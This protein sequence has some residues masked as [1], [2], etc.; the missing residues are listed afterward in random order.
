LPR[1]AELPAFAN[2]CFGTGSTRVDLDL[3][4]GLD[5]TLGHEITTTAYRSH[6][7][8]S[9]KPTQGFPGAHRETYLAAAASARGKEVMD[10]L[11]PDG[12]FASRGGSSA[13]R[14]GTA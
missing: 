14:R 11:A 3:E 13:R 9:R 10:A 6:L 1:I 2:R 5:D 4:P 7:R 12:R 8:R